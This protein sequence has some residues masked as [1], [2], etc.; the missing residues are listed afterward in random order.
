MNI[1]NDHRLFL[2]SATVRWWSKT[3]PE[4]HN[5]RFYILKLFMIP[6]P[7]GW[8]SIG[9][10]L[11]Q[12]SF[13]IEQLK[14]LIFLDFQIF[15]FFCVSWPLHF[16]IFL[17]L[18]QSLRSYVSAGQLT[19]NVIIKCRFHLLAWWVLFQQVSNCCEF[20]GCRFHLLA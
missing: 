20:R 7:F 17:V 14:N 16:Q 3:G 6:F 11:I 9:A 4:K 1:I 12:V 19:A 2:L 8:R 13:L 18:D 10:T 5:I 15:F